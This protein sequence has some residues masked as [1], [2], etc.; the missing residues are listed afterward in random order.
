MMEISAGTSANILHTDM[1]ENDKFIL[2]NKLSELKNERLNK[3]TK[4]FRY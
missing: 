3:L 2:E 4:T 1:K